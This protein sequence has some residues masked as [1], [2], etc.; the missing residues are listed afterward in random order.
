MKKRFTLILASMLLAMGAW[1]ETTVYKVNEATTTLTDGTYVLVAMSNKGT[2]PCYYSS[3]E[4]GNR[5]Y[6]YD[7]NKEVQVG[8]YIDGA[9]YIWTIDETTTN[10][11]QKITVTNVGDPTKAFPVDAARNN[12][13]Q[14][15]GVA[16]LIPELHTI[17]GVDYLAL[18]LENTSV[19]Y[20]HAN[21]PGGNPNLS[22]WN[23]YA[24]GGTCVKFRFYPVEAAVVADRTITYTLTDMAGN[25]YEGTFEGHEGDV[26]TFTGVADYSL[27]NI[28][29]GE[30]SLTATIT[31]PYPVSKVD[32][33]TNATLLSSYYNAKQWHA[34]DGNVL[35][36][37]AGANL[38]ELDY[39]MWAIYPTCNDGAFTFLIKNIATGLYVTETVLAASLILA[40][41][42]ILVLMV[43]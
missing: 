10:G 24:D 29:W 30:N 20:I 3:S 7:V 11:T 33:A 27:D 13:F 12:N 22:Y 31:F 35:V 15:S 28:Q 6:R 16:E 19:G 18:T 14:G 34:V 17:N 23:S 25:S 40:V 43:L 37:T 4:S 42:I 9:Q 2:G 26:P 39:W 36:Q 8:G 1:A 41:T 38:A 32:G 21:A 5:L